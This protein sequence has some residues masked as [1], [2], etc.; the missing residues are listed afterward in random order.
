M[1]SRVDYATALRSVLPWARFNLETLHA[2]KSEKGERPQSLEKNTILECKKFFRRLDTLQK[3][4]TSSSEW[5]E[6]SHRYWEQ[7]IV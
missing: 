3:S 6:K 1:Q 7:V 2:H 4:L 5:T